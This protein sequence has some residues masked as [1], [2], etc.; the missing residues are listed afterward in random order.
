MNL[1]NYATLEASKRLAEAGIVVETDFFY[2][3][4]DDEVTFITKR[5]RDSWLAEVK[6]GNASPTAIFIPALSLAEVW[7][8]LPE[9]YK[10]IYVEGHLYITK[11]KTQTQVGYGWPYKPIIVMQDTNPTDALIGL[12]IWVTEQR[13]K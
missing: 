13:K 2:K 5:E 4:F 6:R 12:L 3:I 7:R 1:N 11:V 8:E 10:S 9:H